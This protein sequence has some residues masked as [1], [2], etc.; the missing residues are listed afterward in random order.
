MQMIDGFA[1]RLDVLEAAVHRSKPHVAYLVEVSQL[2]HHHLAERSRR[3]LALSQHTQLV[4]DARHRGVDRLTADRSLL[5]R[6][7]Q[8]G[9]EFALV[10]GL[11]AAVALDDTRHQ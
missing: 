2:F 4:T 11:A 3:H 10:E 5:Q 6:T 9:A 8:P 1:K 7:D